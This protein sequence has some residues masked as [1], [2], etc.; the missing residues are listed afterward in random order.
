MVKKVLA[1]LC[2]LFLLTGCTGKSGE[3]EQAMGLRAKLLACQGCSFDATITADY[4][5]ELHT[6]GMSCQSDNKGNVTFSVTAPESIAGI[7][8]KIDAS[9][10]KLTFDDKALYFELLADNQITP[11]SGPWILMKTLMGGYIT[12]CGMD[13][14]NLRLSIDDSYEDDALHLDIWLNEDDLP[15]RGEI[16]F[17]GRRIVTMELQNFQIQ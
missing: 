4:G 3:L 10:G 7:T 9:G 5:D 6:F 14:A 16:L 13:G 8:G 11:V 2:M 12:S 15:I 1:V 17:D